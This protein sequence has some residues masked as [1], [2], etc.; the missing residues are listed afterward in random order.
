MKIAIAQI[1][2]VLG[3]LEKNIKKH[4]DFVSEAASKG[5]DVVL[6]PELSLTGYSLKDINYDIALNPHTT[7]KLDEL[8]KLSGKIDIICGFVEED[9]NYKIYNSSAYISSGNIISTHKKIYPPTYTLFEEFRYFS[10]GTECKPFNTKHGKAGLLVCEDMWHISLPYTHAMGGAK[11]IYGLAASPT[12]L[13]TDSA[14]FKNYEINS[15]QHR[16][17][18]RLLSL[19]FVFANRVGFEDG[20]N[21][22]GGSE[23]VDPFGNVIAKGRLFEEELIY[24][25]IDLNE[26]R[27]ARIQARHLNDENIDLTIS[28]LKKLT[29]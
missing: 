17:F 12:R 11:F 24:S 5:A 20:V 3:N 28:N 25:E 4:I 15:E 7:K 16:T 19:Y 22:W 14:E 23:I 27:R 9:N 18:A 26:V 2:S 6:F 21:F 29:E 10:A 1:D 13:G 8:K